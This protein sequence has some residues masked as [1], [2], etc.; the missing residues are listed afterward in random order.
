MNDDVFMKNVKH[1]ITCHLQEIGNFTLD[2]SR[3]GFDS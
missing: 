1:G 2:I 3:Y